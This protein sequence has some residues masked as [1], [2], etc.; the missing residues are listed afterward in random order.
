M[1]LEAGLTGHLVGT[2]MH[3]GTC[4]QVL[5]RLLEMGMEP[6]VITT[7]IRGVLAQRL[8]RRLAPDGAFSGRSL[9][10]EWLPMDAHLRRVILDRGDAE[11]I[12]EARRMAGRPGLR[13]DGERLVREALT[14]RAELDRVLGP[15]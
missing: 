7:A 5:V 6:F 2:T 13:D 3:G 8:V 4:A 11:A 12:E 9:V 15:A 10:T 1:V 14:T